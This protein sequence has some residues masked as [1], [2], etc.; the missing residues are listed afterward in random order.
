MSTPKT[1]EK[2][3][4]SHWRTAVN[5]FTYLE[6]IINPAILDFLCSKPWKVLTVPP[7]WNTPTLL[8]TESLSRGDVIWLSIAQAKRLMKHFPLYRTS[9]RTCLTEDGTQVKLTARNNFWPADSDFSRIY[10]QDRADDVGHRSWS[11]ELLRTLVL[12]P[13]DSQY[14]FGVSCSETLSNVFVVYYV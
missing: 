9:F 7:G 12:Y 14:A 3:F 6:T 2:K 1:D 10:L 13:E 5:S 11:N 8:D 4:H